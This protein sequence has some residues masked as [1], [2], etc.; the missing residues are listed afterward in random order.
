MTEFPLINAA[1][2]AGL[3]IVIF[4]VAF[5]VLSRIA[6]IDIWKE[7]VEQRNLAAAV[8]AGAIALGICWIIAATIH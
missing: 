7:V 8:F 2:F 6:P 5:T 3:G 1:L 4:I